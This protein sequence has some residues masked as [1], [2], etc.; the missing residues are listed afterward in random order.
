MSP[1]SVEMTAVFIRERGET[2]ERKTHCNAFAT[3]FN[4]VSVDL[5]NRFF[6]KIDGIFRIEES[7]TLLVFPILTILSLLSK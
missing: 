6:D 3:G 2:L 5:Q 1:C 7:E 4:R